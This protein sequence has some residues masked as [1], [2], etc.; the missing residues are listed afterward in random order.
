MGC[1]NIS[2]VTGGGSHINIFILFNKNSF[3]SLLDIASFA[4]MEPMA[5]WTRR[6]GMDNMHF[7]SLP[8]KIVSKEGFLVLQFYENMAKTINYKKFNIVY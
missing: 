7:K 4:G 8:C 2:G 6:R 1:G 3:L 5:T